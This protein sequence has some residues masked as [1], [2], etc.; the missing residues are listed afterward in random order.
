MTAIPQS[1]EGAS[2]GELVSRLSSDLSTLI[3]DELR[4]AEAEAGA[5]AKKVGLGLGLFGVAGLIAF[6]GLSALV[7]AAILGLAVVVKA[8]LAALIVGGALIA[9]G[10]VAALLGKRDVAAGPPIPTEAVA[11]IKSDVAALRGGTSR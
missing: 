6:L 10:G 1:T 5:K 2:A 4:L 8:W 9:V 3:R 7:A 11:G